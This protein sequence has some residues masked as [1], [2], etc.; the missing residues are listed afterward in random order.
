MSGLVREALVQSGAVRCLGCGKCTAACPI[1]SRGSDF[2]P[3]MLV[4]WTL[5]QSAVDGR[6]KSAMW[7]CLTCGRCSQRCNSGVDYPAFIR[8]LRQSADRVSEM[9]LCSRGA[10][11]QSLSQIAIGRPQSKGQI[12]WLRPGLTV[13]PESNVLLF[14]GCLPYFDPLVRDVGARPLDIARS[15]VKVLNALGVVPSVLP[16]EACCGHDFLWTGD[17]AS[18]LRLAE[19]NLSQILDSK[20]ETIITPCPECYQTLKVDY[21]RH[22][23]SIGVEVVHLSEYLSE[24]ISDLP[25]RRVPRSIVTF[26]DP[27]RL[28]RFSGLYDQPRQILSAIPGLELR[29]MS[30]SRALAECCGAHA[31]NNCGALAK[32]IQLDILR[33]G[34]STGAGFLVTACPKCEIHLRCAKSHEDGTE[35]AGPGIRDLFSLVADAVS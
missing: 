5:S 19:Y 23:G 16:S 1:S 25:L 27:C 20:A 4:E 12:K 21:P 35:V 7:N 14:V 10:A 33:D 22:L 2:S 17:V 8:Q 32:E 26:H 31:W 28:G 18:F 13:A 30:R 9:Y 3:R 6:V 15:A 29:E 11:V 34:K 24:R